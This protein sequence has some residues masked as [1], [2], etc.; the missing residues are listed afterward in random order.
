MCTWALHGHGLTLGF[1]FDDHNHLELCRKNGFSDLAGGN[2]FDW[3]GH[4]THVWW[5]QQETGWAYYRPLTVAMRVAQLRRFGLNPL[6]FHVVHLS[7][8]SLSV[9]LFYGLLRRC[10]W[11]PAL[12]GGG[13]C[14]SF[15]IR[16]TPSPR[17]GWPTTAPYWSGCGCCG[18]VADARLGASRP[19]P[20]VLLAGVV[21]CYALA[22]LSRENGVMV[23]PLLRPVRFP[24]GPWRRGTGDRPAAPFRRRPGAG[25]WRYTPD[26]LSKA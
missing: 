8:F 17:R 4:I 7:L 5:A 15:S 1:W 18:A 21:L 20:V 11:G 22:L 23:G 2:R 10:G 19:S 16:P 26:W 25:A 24:G 14:S 9:V 3:T 6:P 13:D 12:P